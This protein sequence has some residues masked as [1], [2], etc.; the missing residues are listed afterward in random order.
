MARSSINR[1]GV[2][3][4]RNLRDPR[5]RVVDAAVRLIPHGGHQA[6]ARHAI[7]YGRSAAKHSMMATLATGA[8]A[9]AATGVGSGLQLGATVGAFGQASGAL[10]SVGRGLSNAGRVIGSPVVMQAASI[11]GAAYGLK[12]QH[13]IN[14]TRSARARKG[15][16]TRAEHAAGGSMDSRHPRDK[17]GRFR[18]K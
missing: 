1:A 13:D 5:E 3:L 18:R 8:T 12:K 4:A 7:G 6:A 15:A 10:G 2:F 9:L 14:E 16:R 17:A 11:G